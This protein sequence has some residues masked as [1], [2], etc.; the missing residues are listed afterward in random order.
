MPYLC[1]ML[2]QQLHQRLVV[3]PCSGVLCRRPPGPP[4]DSLHAARPTSSVRPPFKK[5][6][7]NQ[8]PTCAPCSSSSCT[9]ASLSAPAAACSAVAP[10]SQAMLGSALPSSS[11]VAASMCFLSTAYHLQ[12]TTSSILAVLRP[13]F[14][15][16]LPLCPTHA[17]QPRPPSA[18]SGVTVPHPHLPSAHSGVAVPHPHLPSAHSGVTVPHPRPQ[19]LPQLTAVYC[20]PWSSPRPRR[21]CPA[22]PH[23]PLHAQPWLPGDCR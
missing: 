22:T 3:G 14:T 4:S 9:S 6:P 10:P 16:T 11:T 2:Q 23:M 15:S 19:P 21:S 13:L 5:H 8:L 18:L 17:L 12:S 20:R 1:P 7:T